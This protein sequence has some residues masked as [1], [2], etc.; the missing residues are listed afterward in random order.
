MGQAPQTPTATRIV[1]ISQECETLTILKRTSN[2]QRP[3]LR[4]DH[5]FVFFGA[6][7]GRIMSTDKKKFFGKH[8]ECGKLKG[9]VEEL[10]SN[11]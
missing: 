8:K 3:R 4:D 2:S 11:V 6:S 5:F 10:G 7:P 1:L 9:V